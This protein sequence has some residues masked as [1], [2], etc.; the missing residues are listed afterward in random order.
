MSS[1]RISLKKIDDAALQEKAQRD[2][3]QAN[4]VVVVIWPEIYNTINE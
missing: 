2:A 3:A 4:H 1:G